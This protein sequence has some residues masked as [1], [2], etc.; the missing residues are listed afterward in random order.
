[1]LL[2]LDFVDKFI[3][4]IECETPTD[5]ELSVIPL[6]YS[7]SLFF[8]KINHIFHPSTLSATALPTYYSQKALFPISD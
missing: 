7:T 1:L 8:R 5:A 6:I 2:L 4:I 3:L